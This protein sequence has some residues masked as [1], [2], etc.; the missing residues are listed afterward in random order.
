M[1][2]KLTIC[3]T[4]CQKGFT[5]IRYL[6]CHWI[7]HHFPVLCGMLQDLQQEEPEKKSPRK[8]AVAQKTDSFKCNECTEEDT[9]F[10]NVH[11]L[12]RH[13]AS[14]HPEQFF[15]EVE[16]NTLSILSREYKA[17]C[18]QLFKC[19][20]IRKTGNESFGCPFCSNCYVGHL[21]I[22]LHL[23][24]GHWDLMAKRLREILEGKLEGSEDE[25]EVRVEII[26]KEV[27]VEND[28]MEVIILEDD[29]EETYEQFESYNEGVEDPL[30]F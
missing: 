9:Y 16:F 11:E 22:K 1:E 10:P 19:V 14:L 2:S 30:A 13:A 4:E 26:D 21:T 17:R 8:S 7:Q 12:Q 5:D 28:E 6:H 29:V 18:K 25:E 15:P 24:T 20:N 23:V 27:K 3:C